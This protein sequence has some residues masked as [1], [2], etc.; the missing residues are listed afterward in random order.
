MIVK[1]NP[2]L[3]L[4]LPAKIQDELRPSASVTTTCTGPIG[5][6]SRYHT[7]DMLYRL[8]ILL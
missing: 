3:F 8:A 2:E 4:L 7:P 6:R 1:R 5:Q